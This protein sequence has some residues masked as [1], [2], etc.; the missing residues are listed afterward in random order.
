VCC[1][2]VHVGVHVYMQKG[3]TLSVFLNHAFFVCVCVCDMVC[4]WT[5]CSSVWLW[6]TGFREPPVS[7]NSAVS[8]RCAELCPTFFFG[9]FETGFLCIVL[10]VLELTL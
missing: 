4:P 5:C 7:A 2:C 8:D 1:V 9:F 10:A 3:S 6:L